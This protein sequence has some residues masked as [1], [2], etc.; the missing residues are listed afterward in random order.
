MRGCA[1][2]FGPPPKSKSLCDRRRFRATLREGRG[3]MRTGE[4]VAAEM[5][6]TQAV[7][8]FSA[9]GVIESPLY[10]H[11]RRSTVGVL[12]LA[13]ARREPVLIIAISCTESLLV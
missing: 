8:C 3:G 1:A 4:F 9:S 2:P 5:K 6:T 7:C 11:A 13:D 12:K 10:R